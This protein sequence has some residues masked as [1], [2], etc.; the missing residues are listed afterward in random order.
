MTWSRFR[1]G[2]YFGVEV[3]DVADVV[4]ERVVVQAAD[5]VVGFGAVGAVGQ[6]GAEEFQQWRGGAV[7]VFED[8]L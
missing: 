8:H 3:V 2:V 6:S 5:G 4:G 7:A 1:C